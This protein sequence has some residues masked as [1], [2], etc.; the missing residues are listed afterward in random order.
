M[1]LFPVLANCRK[2]VH[3]W[4]ERKRMPPGERAV[5]RALWNRTNQEREDSK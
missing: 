5:I 3:P 2:L 4:D 1:K